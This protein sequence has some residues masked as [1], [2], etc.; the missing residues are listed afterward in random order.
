[1]VKKCLSALLAACMICVTA[2]ACASVNESE[3]AYLSEEKV[4]T[5]PTEEEIDQA[6]R[7]LASMTKV[8][9]TQRLELWV[10]MA[11]SE[12]CIRIKPP[13]K[14]SFPTLPASMKMNGQPT[15]ISR[16]CAAKSS[17]SITHC[18]IARPR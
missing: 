1:M 8:E 5:P 18:R 13:A 17:W 15:T 12:L 7:G 16:C 4:Y 10:N 11:T 3:D 2:A 9:E 14:P 6:N